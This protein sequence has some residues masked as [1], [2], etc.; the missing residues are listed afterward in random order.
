MKIVF[1]ILCLI[2]GSLLLA[3]VS[4]RDDTFIGGDK[5][6]KDRYN[7]QKYKIWGFEKYPKNKDFKG[8]MIVISNS[9]VSYCFWMPGKVKDGKWFAFLGMKGPSNANWYC[10][11]FFKITSY[12]FDSTKAPFEVKDVA[13]GE[14]GAFTACW[15]DGG[16]EFE[17]KF[18][19]PD[20]AEQ[21]LIS[22][23]V[24]A[25]PP[26]LKAYFV[27]MLCYPS[28]M[29]GGW[30]KGM[31]LRKRGALTP[32][33]TVNIDQKG[34]ELKLDKKE[35]WCLFYD[36][37]FDFGKSRG[38][39]PCAFLYNPQETTRAIV[40]VTNYSCNAILA[41]PVKN[42]AN[43]MLWDFHKMTNKQAMDYM[44]SLKVS[45]E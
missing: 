42:P 28:S 43:I 5:A 12:K 16:F 32:S 15:K 4:V 20:N 30:R 38:E 35:N 37:Y 45:D 36:S 24:I 9:K 41:Y 31:K 27:D 8:R 2:S 14:V 3:E 11:G 34:Q 33:R 23:K 22:T 44:K 1:T 10:N 13:K 17:T 40:R 39:G 18:T 26:K 29:A 19:L 7:Q 21:L 25:A 6:S